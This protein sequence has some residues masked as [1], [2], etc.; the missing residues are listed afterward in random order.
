[1]HFNFHNAKNQ[2]ILVVKKAVVIQA[3]AINLLICLVIIYVYFAVTVN[4]LHID[5]NSIIVHVQITYCTWRSS[6]L[7]TKIKY[8]YH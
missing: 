3:I 4:M 6:M 8:S 5:C 2:F 7:N 1:M